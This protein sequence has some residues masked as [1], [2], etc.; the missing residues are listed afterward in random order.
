MICHRGLLIYI[1]ETNAVGKIESNH[2]PIAAYLDL[3]CLRFRRDRPIDLGE[4]RPKQPF[5]I[6]N[7]ESTCVLRNACGRTDTNRTPKSNREAEVKS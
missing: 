2:W 3:K 5:K 6:S 7:L 1:I 4:A